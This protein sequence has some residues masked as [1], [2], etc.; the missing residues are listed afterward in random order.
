MKAIIHQLVTRPTF[1]R[2]FELGK[3]VTITGSMQAIVQIVGF[4]SGILVIRLL[5]TS[6]YAIYILANT[7]LGTMT[8]LADGGISTGVMAQGGKVWHNP[9][10]LGAVL[11]TGLDLR[12]KF[13]IVSLIVAIPVMIYLMRVHDATWVMSLVVVLAIVPAFFSALSG[14]LLQ[15]PPKLAQDVTSLQRTLVQ[16]NLLRLML[17]GPALFVFPFAYVAVLAGGLPQIWANIRFRRIASA[18][19]D[20]KQRPDVFI[21]RE[22]MVFIKRIFPGAIYFC[23]SGQISIWLISIFGATA[24]LAQVGALARLAMILTLFTTMFNILI[25]PRF[26]RL[27]ENRRLLVDRYIKIQL[28]LVVVSVSMVTIVW[29]FPDQVLWILGS[30]YNHLKDELVLCFIGTCLN[31]FVGINYGLN[32]SR[33]WLLHPAI[34][35]AGGIAG[36]ICGVLLIDISTIKGVLWFNMFTGVVGLFIHPLYGIIKLLGTKVERL[37]THTVGIQKHKPPVG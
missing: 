9:A 34:G 27:E 22:L 35:I 19:A 12:S 11:A 15:I 28:I 31:L 21:R 29:L 26:A 10:K 6:E 2:A 14:S 37:S 32:A 4:L 20:W 23:V 7:M 13:A 24:A 30:K 25:V 3:L 5:P 8:V 36:I 16:S 18:Y 1:S 33:G 17:I